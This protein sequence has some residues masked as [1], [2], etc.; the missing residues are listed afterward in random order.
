[1]TAKNLHA[2]LEEARRKTREAEAL[3]M[4]LRKRKA[5][6]RGRAAMEAEAAIRGVLDFWFAREPGE[7]RPD[8]FRNAWFA[9]DDAFDDECRAKLGPL[10][11]RAAAGELNSWLDTEEGSLAIILLLDQAPRNLHRGTAQAFATDAM[12]LA[13]ARATVAKGFDRALD[14]TARM[15]VYLPYEHAEDRAA[16]DE[17][18]ALMEA[19]PETPWR[20]NV[21]DYAHRHRAVIAEFGRFPHRNAVLGRESTEAEKAYLAR[22]G[23]GF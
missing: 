20:A 21:V 9:K 12:A 8:E 7:F 16:Q 1:M 15:F 10:A 19:L 13:A 5:Q 23:S 11:E 3:R 2:Q 6:A 18:C 17:A 4:N 22:P 14:P